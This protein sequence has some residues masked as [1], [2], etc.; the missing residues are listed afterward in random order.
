MFK[1]R[2]IDIERSG[3]IFKKIEAYVEKVVNA[4]NPHAVIL[5]GSFATGNINEGSDIDIL[6][7]ADFK[8]DFLSRIKTLME[9]NTFGIPIE[10]IGYTLEEFESM[11]VRGNRFIMEVMEKG[12]VLYK[13]EER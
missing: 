6:I 9:L 4:L 1:L 5:F 7:I 11:R 12:K 3:E 2:R 8:E 13:R 10:P